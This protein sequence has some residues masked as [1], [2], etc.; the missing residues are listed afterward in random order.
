MIT[1]GE[2]DIVLFPRA[3][4]WLSESE[5]ERIEMLEDEAEREA[6][7]VRQLDVWLNDEFTRW[8]WFDDVSLRIL[9]AVFLVSNYCLE[10]E[11]QD[12]ILRDEVALDS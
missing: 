12:S 2:L 8:L 1:E 5:Y 10:I 3:V 4:S 11:F 9:E 6:D 7:K